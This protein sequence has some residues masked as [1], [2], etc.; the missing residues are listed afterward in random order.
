MKNMKTFEG[1]FKS[2]FGSEEKEFLSS[3]KGR[4]FA[5]LRNSMRRR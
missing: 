4:K 3:E 5:D 1:F 2:L